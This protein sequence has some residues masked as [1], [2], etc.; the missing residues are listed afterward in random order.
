MRTDAASRGQLRAQGFEQAF[1]GVLALIEHFFETF[2]AAEIGIDDH[3]AV[4]P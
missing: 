2:L 4:I 1:A 3:A